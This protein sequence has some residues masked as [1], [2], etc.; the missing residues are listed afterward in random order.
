VPDIF[1]P[2]G[3]YPQIDASFSGNVTVNIAER[4][5]ET[6][7][8]TS[9]LHL[10]PAFFPVSGQ[11]V[12]SGNKINS[13]IM[14]F[15]VPSVFPRPIKGDPLFPIIW[16]RENWR[17]PRFEI[18][19]WDRYPSILI[20]DFADFA[21]QSRM[22]HRLAFY[23][24]KAGFRGRLSHDYEIMHLHGW[25]AHNYRDYDLARFFDTARQTNFPLLDEEWELERI[26]LNEGII[27]KE[28][29][30]IVPGEGA[31]LSITRQSPGWLRYRFTAH[32]VFHGLYFRD[33]AFREFSR[34]RWYAFSETG[35]RFLTA[36]L[37]SQQYDTN[38]E[39]LL[40]NEFM[41]FTMQQSIIGAADYFG[42]HL[43]N[44]VLNTP[45]YWAVPPRDPVTG[46][47]P[48]L[49]DIFTV[50]AEAFTDYVVRR[51]GLA[52]GRVWGFRVR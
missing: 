24:E 14:N 34:H 31:I 9:S 22:L 7:D 13:F 5:L 45:Y 11:A 3:K 27:I 19:S 29:G 30:R 41:G 1:M 51:W 21:I 32:E 10:P 35:R 17:D 46:T 16:P 37:D 40:I 6:F 50:E 49:A 33:E 15:T 18:F 20:F 2:Q 25:N 23:V 4:T 44:V 47:W 39:F 8:G 48:Y 43:P 52:A 26:L 38:Y 12:I 36:F 28:N 42:R